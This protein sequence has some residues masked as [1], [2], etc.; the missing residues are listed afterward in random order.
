MY[1]ITDTDTGIPLDYN[2]MLAFCLDNGLTFV[3]VIYPMRMLSES[4][5]AILE[6]ADGISVYGNNVLREGL[7]WRTMDQSI[8]FKAKSRKYAMW[9]GKEDKTE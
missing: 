6:D 1:K 4:L 3:P 5:D 2:S 7:V 8:G 9:F